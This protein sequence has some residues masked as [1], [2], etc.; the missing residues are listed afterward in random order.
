MNF[1]RRENFFFFLHTARF[2]LHNFYLKEKKIGSL[3]KAVF[4]LWKIAAFPFLSVA[5]VRWRC[6][7]PEPPLL[8]QKPY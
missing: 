5:L 1:S 8:R 2:F 7:L 6:L 3:K 4:F